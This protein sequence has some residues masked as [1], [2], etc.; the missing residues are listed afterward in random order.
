MNTI[1]NA[2]GAVVKRDDFGSDTGERYGVNIL[3][4]SGIRGMIASNASQKKAANR[5]GEM[6]IAIV[7]LAVVFVTERAAKICCRL[8]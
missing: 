4:Q 3:V 6:R 1:N 8:G 2:H 5:V 7:L